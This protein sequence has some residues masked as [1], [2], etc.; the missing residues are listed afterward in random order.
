MGKCIYLMR[1]LSA[2]QTIPKAGRRARSHV[3]Q[4]SASVERAPSCI[5]ARPAE[6]YLRVCGQ[7]LSEQITQPWAAMNSQTMMHRYQKVVNDMLAYLCMTLGSLK[8]EKNSKG[9]GNL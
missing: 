3:H 9:R 8:H 1:S 7:F 6:I 2:M 4:Y 5:L